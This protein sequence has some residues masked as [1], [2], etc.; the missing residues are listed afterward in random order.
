MTMRTVSNGHMNCLANYA[1][2]WPSHCLA[3]CPNR[4]GDRSEVCHK[5]HPPLKIPPPPLKIPPHLR[6]TP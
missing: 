4:K 5:P 2:V 1:H 3:G 6:Y